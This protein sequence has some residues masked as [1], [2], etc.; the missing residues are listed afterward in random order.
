VKGCDTF[1]KLCSAEADGRISSLE[2][3]KTGIQMDVIGKLFSGDAIAP[4]Q[5][6]DSRKGQDNAAPLR[7]LMLAVLEDALDCMRRGASNPA[8]AAL[9]KAARE[10][11]EWVND[12]TDEHLFSFNCVCET[13]GIHPGALRESL[14]VW[15]AY[16][17]RLTRRAPVIRETAVSISPGRRRN[18]ARGFPS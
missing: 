3:A 7:G 12:T 8:S 14:S 17:S 4:S 18:G 9:R 2:S 11:A 10:A 5:F 16:G 15:I 13:L 1:S 6:R